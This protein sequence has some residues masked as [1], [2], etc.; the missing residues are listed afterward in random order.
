MRKRILLILVTIMLG[1]VLGGLGSRGV[2]AAVVLNLPDDFTDLQAQVTAL[3]A[4]P[5]FDFLIC[6]IDMGGDG[7]FLV[8]GTQNLI[9]TH[10]A[11]HGDCLWKDAV[12]IGDASDM[13][14]CEC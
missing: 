13:T 8:L 10:L 1:V 9:D 5:L 7:H 14:A 11:Q 3:G 2:S 6:H 12:S 4:P